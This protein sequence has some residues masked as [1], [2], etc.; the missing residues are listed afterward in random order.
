M[1]AGTSSSNL[2]GGF[3]QNV[4]RLAFYAEDS[5]RAAGNLTLNY[6]L[7][8]ST[9]YGLFTSSGRS[10]LQ[11]PGYLTLTALRIPLVSGAPHDDRKQFAPRLGFAY[12]P[13]RNGRTVVR[14]GFGLYFDDLAQNGWATA[15]QAVS[16]PPVPALTPL[17]INRGPRT[18]D[19]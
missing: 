8:Y 15:F 18:Q 16:A 19:A 7:R 13:G 11:N 6:G 17:L 2:G 9:T 10:Q 12:S 3:S 4:Q 1:I 5:W 14:G